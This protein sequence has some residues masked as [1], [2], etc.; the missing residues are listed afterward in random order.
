MI[1][2][3]DIKVGLVFT[4]CEK[5]EKD[6]KGWILHSIAS[7]GFGVL[8]KDKV[9]LPILFKIVDIKDN[10]VTIETIREFFVMGNSHNTIFGKLEEQWTT[11]RFCF[12]IEEFNRIITETGKKWL[13]MEEI[14]NLNKCASNLSEETV[15][16]LNG[17]R[18]MSQDVMLFNRITGEMQ[19][20]YIKKNHD[21]GNAFS[22]MYDELG[23]NYGYG[24]IREKVNRIKTLKDNE[25]QVANE[26]LEDALLDCA[27]YC[28]L[29]LMEYKK[30]KEHGTD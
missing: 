6:E 18:D 22:E 24:K 8:L 25:A 23:I 4:L 11:T 5:R 13:S 27:N 2:K 15:N 17:V 19:E 20:T 26:P 12:G 9:D 28:I 1:K 30:R 3:E 16:K 14:I 7:G 29:T 21:Y 10:S